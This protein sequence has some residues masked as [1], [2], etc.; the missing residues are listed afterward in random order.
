MDI[1][2]PDKLIIANRRLEEMRLDFMWEKLLP[3]M[4][5]CDV[6]AIDT[7]VKLCRAKSQLLGLD[8]TTQTI[9]ENSVRQELTS[10]IDDKFEASFNSETFNRILTVIAGMTDSTEDDD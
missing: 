7:S 3:A 9:V 8:A 5:D 1:S 2:S 6:K 10:V 4:K